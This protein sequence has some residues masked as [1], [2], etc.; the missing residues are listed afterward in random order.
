MVTLISLIMTQNADF[1]FLKPIIFV[2]ILNY[3]ISTAQNDYLQIDQV[4]QCIAF[5]YVI[6]CFN[7]KPKFRCQANT[8]KELKALNLTSNPEAVKLEI[9]IK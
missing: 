2:M 5:S 6:Y 8:F 1:S 7:L 9:R 3:R 4:F